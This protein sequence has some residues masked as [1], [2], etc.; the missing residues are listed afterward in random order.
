VGEE[1]H[2]LARLEGHLMDNALGKGLVVES[3]VRVQARRRGG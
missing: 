2:L 1:Q 3:V